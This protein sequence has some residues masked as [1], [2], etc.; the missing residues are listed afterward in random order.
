MSTPTTTRTQSESRGTLAMYISGFLLSVLMTVFAYTVVVRHAFTGDSLIFVLLGL[1]VLQFFAQLY[2]F[3]HVGSETKPRYK[4]LLLWLMLL[5][6][7]VV[8]LGSIWVMYN[9]NYHMSPD[10]MNH[11]LKIQD[12]GI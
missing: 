9:L 11:Y 4:L 3:L 1:A 8:V 7:I 2:F 10:Q 5:I 6:V 12:G